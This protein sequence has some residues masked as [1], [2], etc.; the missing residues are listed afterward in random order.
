MKVNRPCGKFVVQMQ[1][2]V[3]VDSIAIAWMTGCGPVRVDGLGSE[4]IQLL[5]AW[6]E[7]F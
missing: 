1:T 5:F 7:F 2:S 3:R 6:M 4:R